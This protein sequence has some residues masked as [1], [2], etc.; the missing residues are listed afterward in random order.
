[1]KN[2]STLNPNSR[3][4]ATSEVHMPTRVLIVRRK[5]KNTVRTAR[6]VTERT[7]KTITNR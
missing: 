3:E 4:R 7:E 5:E 1:M 6:K 2:P